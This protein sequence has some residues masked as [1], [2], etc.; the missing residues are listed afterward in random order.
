MPYAIYDGRN[1][2]LLI[3]HLSINQKID[4][5][6]MLYNTP[7]I[8]AVEKKFSNDKELLTYLDQLKNYCK[9]VYGAYGDKLEGIQEDLKQSGGE[10]YDYRM[11]DK[12]GKEVEEG[13][14]ILSKGKIFKKYVTA[15]DIR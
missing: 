11:L 3:D 8:L 2:Y 5:N 6:E 14:L 4:V 9:K 10:F 1:K 12:K 13:W 15:T 7:P